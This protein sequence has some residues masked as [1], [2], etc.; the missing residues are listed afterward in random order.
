V[1]D[2]DPER[3]KDDS[4]IRKHVHAYDFHTADL[5]GEFESCY[6]FIDQAVGKNENILIHCH[7]GISSKKKEISLFFSNKFIL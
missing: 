6:E 2:F 5:I 1:L 7:A 4:R 3:P